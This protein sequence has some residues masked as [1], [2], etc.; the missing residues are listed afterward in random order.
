[1]QNSRMK[2]LIWLNCFRS[3]GQFQIL[4]FQLP[5]SSVHHP[6]SWVQ[7]LSSRV[8]SPAT[9]FCVQSSGIPVCHFEAMYVFEFVHSV[10]IFCSFLLL[11][12]EHSL[13]E[14]RQLGFVMLNGNLAINLKPTHLPLLNGK[15]QFTFL[16]TK[17]SHF[18]GIVVCP[19]KFDF[20]R[21]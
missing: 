21:N 20:F 6:A 15:G 17:S 2:L 12:S 5:Q 9:N 14:Q 11:F 7:S 18:S 8:Q 19:P 10:F 13:R 4:K 16:K 3:F 1:M